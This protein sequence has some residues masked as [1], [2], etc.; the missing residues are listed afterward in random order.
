MI[1]GGD[2]AAWLGGLLRLTPRMTPE[3][4]ATAALLGAL[5]CL[6]HGT[7]TVADSGPTG[8]GVAALRAAGLRGTVHVE[9]FGRL[10]GV[11]AR[12]AASA[13]AA[14]AR[15]LDAAAGPLIR[16]GVSPHAPY[17]VGPDFWAALVA[18]PDLA[19][20][21]W[22]T[23]LAESPSESRLLTAGDGP[24]AE[25]FAT[26]GAVP[27]RWP[28]AGGPV[29]RL[30]EG[31]ALRPGLVAAHC[32]QLD[33]D[34]PVR[35]RDAGVAVAHCPMSNR[36]LDCGRFPIERLRD[37]GVTMGLGT[38]S[39]ASAGHYDVRAEA[40]ACGEEHRHLTSLRAGELLRLATM[41]GAEALGLGH[42]IGTIETG[43]RADLVAV[44]PPPG[45]DGSDPSAAALDA[46]GVVALVM[47]DGVVALER[48]VPLTLDRDAIQASASAAR[49]RLIG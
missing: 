14:R 16:V 28:G 49:A 32:V 39:P 30:H 20:R 44:M 31:G 41:G 43:K 5:R 42:A 23:H 8:V 17:T 27:G 24:L 18:D 19:G 48:G 3:D 13:I 15:G 36:R 38:D 2:F 21:S 6:E 4:H 33:R 9:A 1:D 12:D 11:Q 37:A 26:R 46:D 35:L 22:A 7:T 40:R 47:V 34:D 25:L 10:S 45:A 29:A